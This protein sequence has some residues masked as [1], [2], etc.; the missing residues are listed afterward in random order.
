MMT[1]ARTIAQVWL[2][3]ND[4]AWIARRHGAANG[5]VVGNLSKAWS[6]LASA[7]VAP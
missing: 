1:I 2:G 3:C 4:P 6:G 5:P 7:T